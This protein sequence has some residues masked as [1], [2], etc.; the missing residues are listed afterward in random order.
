MEDAATAEISR[1]QVWQWVKHGSKL[2]DGRTVTAA[3]VLDATKQQLDK[4][5][6]EL[7]AERFAQGKFSTAAQLFNQMMTA[8]EFPEFLTLTAY[9]DID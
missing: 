5:R 3:L 1:A 6:G 2:N 8:E 4:L 9:D 7:G